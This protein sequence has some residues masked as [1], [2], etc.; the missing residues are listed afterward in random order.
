MTH[1]RQRV[2][3]K[4]KAFRKWKKTHGRKPSNTERKIFY[5]GFNMGWIDG[6]KRQQDI[7]KEE[8]IK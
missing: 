5:T 6:K 8:K 1:G 7:T 4:V 3:C 2:I